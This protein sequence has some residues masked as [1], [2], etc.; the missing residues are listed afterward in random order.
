MMEPVNLTWLDGITRMVYTLAAAAVPLVAF[1][2]EPVGIELEWTFPDGRVVR[3]RREVPENHGVTVFGLSRGEIA[4]RQASSV[5]ITPDFARAHKGDDGFWVFSSGECGTF[6]C[7]EGKAECRRWQLM[8]TYGMKS[9]ERTF[10]AIVRKLKY[11]FK[12]R[13]VAKNGEY[14]MSCVL[15][16]ELCSRPYEDFEIE[17]RRLD[18]REATM[19]G[20]ARAYRAYQFGRGA[21][22][23]LKERAAANNVLTTAIESPEIRIRQAWKP[24]PPSILDQTPEN[25]PPVTPYVTF[26]RVV[27]IARAL[28]ASGVAKAELCLVGWNIGGHDGRWPQAFPAEPTLGGDEKLRQCIREVRDM[29]YLIVP[30]GNY[31]DAY[32]IADSWDEEW[33]AK[34]ESGGFMTSGNWGGGRSSRI[35]ARRAYELFVTRDMPRMGALG[36]RG[37]GYFDVVSIVMADECHDARHPLSRAEAA[38]WWGKGAA[39]SKEVFGGF[40]SEGAFDH[41]VGDLDSALYVSFKDPTKGNNGLVDRMAPFPQLVY[42]GVFAM[43]PFTRTVNF[44]AQEKYW[45][46]KLIEFGGRP[47]FYFYSKFKSDGKNWMGDGDLGC[48]TDEE[49]ARSIAKIKE[50]AGIYCRLAPLQ[51]EFM[52]EHDYL[53]KG[54]WRTTY[55]NGTRVYDNYGDAAVV[56]D[57][58]EIPAEGWTIR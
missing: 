43:N 5:A 20:M 57:G 12:T 46:L 15:D 14:R 11:Y 35:C 17:F 33:L 3:E 54:V 21:A 56:A 27:N 55:S 1:P 18:G 8:S 53:G 31:I 32:R 39:L 30:H 42:N 48:A 23:P 9:P 34:T 22:K 44:T 4:G 47:T 41:F 49:L 26:D 51:F 13:V 6:R 10:V 38:Q 19:G 58:V 29:G 40:A 36:F 45:Q 16:H 50:G 28:K 37:L 52:E 7:D 24:V 2:A 25:E